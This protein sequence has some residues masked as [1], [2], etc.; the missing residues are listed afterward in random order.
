MSLRGRL[1]LILVLTNL[2]VL[3]AVQVSALFIQRRWEDQQR[4]VYQKAMQGILAYAYGAKQKQN[5]ATVRRL[6]SVPTLEQY[7]QDLMISHGGPLSGSVDLNPLGA[8]RRRQDSFPL[9]S[10]RASIR[11]AMTSENMVFVAGGVCLPIRSDE[12]VVAGAWFIPLFPIPPSL[13]FQFLVL[14]FLLSILPFIV[15]VNWVVARTVVR[16]LHSLGDAAQRLGAADYSVRAPQVTRSPE[17]RILVD[18]FNA[19][20]AK[21]EGHTEELASEVKLATEEAA[22]RERALVVSSRLASLGT[23]AAGIAHE[24]NNPIGGMLN[25]VHRLAQN[26]ELGEKEREYLEL[27]RD[28]LS[29]VARTT[30]KVLDFS[31]RKIET[32]AF[33]LH[34]AVQQ[35]LALVEHRRA[36]QGV[37]LHLDLPRDLQPLFGEPHEVQQVFLNLFLNSLDALAAVEAG[38]IRVQ[39]KALPGEV[40]ILVADNGPGVPKKLL[41]RLLDPFFSTQTRPDATGLGLFICYSIVQNHGGNLRLASPPDQGFQVWIRLPLQPPE[42]A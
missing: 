14:P 16:P 34:D 23:L 3:G 24:V 32:R 25:A 13:P 6:L 19:M 38:E 28:G 30:R 12:K 26:P 7:F 9:D 36:E 21:V 41:D 4:V 18:S 39:A 17:L 10:V 42:S 15:L 37:T 20:A 29:R 2:L 5:W 1:L 27:V 22:R 8:V 31:P 35:A 40:E 33:S 11:E